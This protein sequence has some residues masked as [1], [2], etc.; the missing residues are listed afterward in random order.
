MPAF[1]YTALDAS[2]RTRKGV[3]EGDSPR[4][5]R[6]RL[7][8]QG[9]TPMSVSQVAERAAVLRMPVLQQ[10]IK[11]LELALATRQMA[12]LARAGLPIEEVLATVARQSESPKV[13]SALTA[14][15]TRV[16]EGL[17]L[18]HA[19]GEFPSVFPVIYRTTIAAG[20]Q[21][22][23]LDLVLERLADNVEAQNAMRQKIQLAMFYPAILTCVA[24]LVTVALLTYVVPEV[25]KVFD[26]M[27]Q[28]LPL[29]TRMLIAVSDTLR[30]W[31][32]LMLLILGGLGY[33]LRTLLQ[34]PAYQRRW[35]DLLLRLPLIGRLTRG[36]NTARFART[37]NIL[38]ASGVPLLD[39][40][41]M[42]ASVITNLPMREAV[43]EAAQRVREGAGVGLAL[44]RSGYFPAMT[45]SLIKSGESSGTLDDMLERAAETQERELEARIAMVMGVF[46]PLLILTMGAVVLVIVLA[47]LLPIFELNQLVN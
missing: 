5:V 8:E 18:A 22:G 33:G 24:L 6:G 17:P 1:E 40:L 41:N 9:L 45:L 20:E 23:R 11:P 34:R 44:E 35:H 16:M 46:E 3:E 13:R 36:L 26:G 27:N 37:L 2:G 25:V 39:A 21:A 47:I 38:A 30:D 12:T 14:V 43:S 19:L 28:Q 31:G 4:Q 7:R 15:R 10:R 29:L 32:L 42:S